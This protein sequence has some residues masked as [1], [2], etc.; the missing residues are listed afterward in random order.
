MTITILIFWIKSPSQTISKNYNMVDSQNLRQGY[1]IDPIPFE[2]G[3][4]VGTLS[5]IYYNNK[6]VGVWNL[7][8]PNG[9]IE[10]QF[11]YYDTLEHEVQYN[12]YYE[13]RN[14]KSTGFKYPVA[15]K[16]TVFAY[17]ET[18]GQLDIPVYFDSILMKQG[19]WRIYYRNGQLESEG[20][21]IND[22]KKGIWYYYSDQGTLLKREN[23]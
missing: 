9:I 21:Y 1:W 5:G 12:E 16:D 18:T 20:E 14:F 11:I 7:R 10:K 6:K 19:K 2:G 23:N 17:N 4:R 15:K 13:N 8:T 3:H 22:I